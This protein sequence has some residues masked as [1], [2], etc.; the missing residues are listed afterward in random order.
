MIIEHNMIAI[1]SV[2]DRI[3]VMNYG[4]KIAEG[5]PSEVRDDP[6]VVSAYLGVKKRVA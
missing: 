5:I 2:C 1:F 6:V 3:A 4:T